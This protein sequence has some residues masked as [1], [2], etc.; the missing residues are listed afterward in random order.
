MKS[1]VRATGGASLYFLGVASGFA[2]A[3]PLAAVAVGAHAGTRVTPVAGLHGPAIAYQSHMVNRSTKAT[4]LGI[5]MPVGADN[6]SMVAKTGPSPSGDVATGDAAPV[7]AQPPRGAPTGTS[8]ARATPK[9]C[10]SSIGA[11]RANL[12]TD[13][14]TVCVADASVIGHIE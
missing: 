14:L 7:A 13:E 1:L 9:G 2:L 6:S 3:I 5:P 10:L 8:P 4:R 12:A 11:T